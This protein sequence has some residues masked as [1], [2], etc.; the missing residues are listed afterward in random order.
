[1]YSCSKSLTT[2]P[3]FLVKW[4][5]IELAFTVLPLHMMEILKLVLNASFLHS[6]FMI[7]IF[8]PLDGERDKRFPV[9]KNCK[10]LLSFFFNC[11]FLPLHKVCFCVVQLFSYHANILRIIYKSPPISQ[12]ITIGRHVTHVD[13]LEFPIIDILVNSPNC[14]YWRSSYNCNRTE[15]FS[16][17]LIYVDGLVQDCS[18][19]SALAMEIY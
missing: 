10:L 16:D 2:W 1:M 15:L 13:I 19:S 14:Q 3:A 9:C 17:T 6:H 12:C 5:A 7:G 4:K 18:I 11:C 8:I